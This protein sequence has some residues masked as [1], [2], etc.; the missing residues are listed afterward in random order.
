M[1]KTVIAALTA[2]ATPSSSAVQAA[3]AV[4]RSTT[5]SMTVRNGRQGGG[6]SGGGLSGPLPGDPGGV[7]PCQPGARMPESGSETT[8]RPSAETVPVPLM[9]SLPLVW[10]KLRM[11]SLV[12]GAA[13]KTLGKVICTGS[14]NAATPGAWIVMS[15]VCCST[16]GGS[17]SRTSSAGTVAM[18]T[19]T[20]CSAWPFSPMAAPGWMVNVRASRSCSVSAGAACASST[21][22]TVGAESL[23]S[24]ST[25]VATRGR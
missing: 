6:S 22:I 21:V 7:R 20:F 4:V 17:M 24:C 18:P 25:L 11:L 8:V 13:L 15:K 3:A 5:T 1:S 9:T 19:R 23:T 12:P 16:P 10:S 2:F 14:A